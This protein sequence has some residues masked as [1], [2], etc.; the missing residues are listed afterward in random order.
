[1]DDINIDQG[2]KQHLT[3]IGSKESLCTINV[4]QAQI[5]AI[6]KHSEEF[7]KKPS[8]ESQ[9]ITLIDV[10]IRGDGKIEMIDGQVYFSAMKFLSTT[11]NN[12]GIN[13]NLLIVLYIN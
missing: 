6:K 2:L 7:Q 12:Q 11:Y 5:F 4:M 1:M 13:F 9:N 3:T 10:G 8:E